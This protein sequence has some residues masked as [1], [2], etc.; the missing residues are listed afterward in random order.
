MCSAPLRGAPV[1]SANYVETNAKQNQLSLSFALVGYLF[2]Y[3]TAGLIIV[4][5]KL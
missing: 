5:L 4:L 3:R 1:L 2:V